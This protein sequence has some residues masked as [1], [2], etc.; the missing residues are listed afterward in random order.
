MDRGNNRAS[1]HERATR[2][3][4]TVRLLIIPGAALAVTGFILKVLLS[5]GPFG[6]DICNG[7]YRVFSTWH[8]R[9]SMTV[10]LTNLRLCVLPNKSFGF[11]SVPAMKYP[12]GT[13]LP[14][15]IPYNSIVS[16]E[17]QK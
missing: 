7:P 8:R 11:L 10:E 9:N 1:S 12:W 13:R 14:L 16:V 4:R 15:E 6:T 17:L 3:S 2:R 5:F